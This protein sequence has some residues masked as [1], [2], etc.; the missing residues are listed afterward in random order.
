MVALS[1][2]PPDAIDLLHA[3]ALEL[4]A[5]D[6]GSTVYVEK[7]SMLHIFEIWIETNSIFSATYKFD[8]A[9]ITSPFIRGSIMGSDL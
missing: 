1:V 4:G 3:K 9:D 7:T 2:A 8:S 6:E 5:T